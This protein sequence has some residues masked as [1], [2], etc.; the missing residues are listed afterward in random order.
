MAPIPLIALAAGAG[1]KAF[2]SIQQG[3]AQANQAN[4][5]ADVASFNAANTRA[6]ITSSNAETNAAEEKQNRDFGQLQGTAFAATA[7]SGTGFDGSNALVLKQ[8][9]INNE[10]DALTIRYQ[11]QQK[12]QGLLAQAESYDS[13]AAADR[14]NAK[15][16]KIGG[17][18]GAGANLL[19]GYAQYANYKSPAGGG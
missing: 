12:A 7:Q 2:G 1:L 16:A 8:N 3:Y 5:A 13:Q 19:S 17:F 14:A 18:L 6:A 11:G 15:G 10:L 4:A 9:A